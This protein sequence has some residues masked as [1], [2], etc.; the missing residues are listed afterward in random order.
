[1]LAVCTHVHTHMDTDGGEH[2]LHSKRLGFRCQLSFL[3]LSFPI[4]K[5]GNSAPC[6]GL[7]ELEGCPQCRG[8]NVLL[9][10]I[11]AI[12][13]PTQFVGS[14]TQKVALLRNWNEVR[15]QDHSIGEG[16]GAQRQEPCGWAKSSRSQKLG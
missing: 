15:R 13:L 10:V 1:M 4:C 6:K 8:G 2:R 3:S 5:M 14:A 11:L 16:E 12:K 9:R 7:L